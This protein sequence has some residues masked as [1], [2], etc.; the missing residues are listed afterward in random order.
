[1]KYLF[2]L[3][4]PLFVL[5]VLRRGSRGPSAFVGLNNTGKF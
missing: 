5:A 2:F 3:G 1:M 4:L